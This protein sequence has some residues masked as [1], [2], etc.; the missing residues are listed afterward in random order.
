[1]CIWTLI[2]VVGVSHIELQ[3]FGMPY[4]STLEY[5][6]ILIFLKSE[7]NICYLMI[8]IHLNLLHFYICEK[9]LV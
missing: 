7:Q 4:L 8:L 5:Q 1:M 3:D 2:M 9:L 6:Q